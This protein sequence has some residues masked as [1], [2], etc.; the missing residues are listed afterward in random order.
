MISNKH[1]FLVVFFL[2]LWLSTAVLSVSAA[3]LPLGTLNASQ[4]STLFSG[5]TV[6]ANSADGKG[7]ELVSYFSPDG[8]Y[9][10]TRKG[11]LKS[12]TWK[13]RK[14][15]R[16][17]IKIEGKKQDCRIIVQQ[18]NAYLRYAVK[19]EGNHKHELTYTRFRSGQRL[20]QMSD[21]PILPPGTLKKK[22]VIELFADKTVESV[23]A[24][25]GRVS[26]TYYH[27]DGTIEQFRAGNKRYGTWR[28]TKN[29]RI[30][31]RMENLQEKCRII[32]KEGNQFK[33]Y[34]VKKNN[35][36]QHSVTYRQFL[37]GKTFK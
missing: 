2:I 3:E 11:W 14:D 36:H 22:A 29:G 26:Q 33:K 16:L 20:A 32:V 27:P 21:D 10:E 31:L 30:C 12:G 17:C 23:T 25:K 7:Q 35:N 15:D 1:V 8:Q 34:I 13:I 4:I 28:V 19:L 18:G 6:A 5:K 37:N 9:Q 24:R